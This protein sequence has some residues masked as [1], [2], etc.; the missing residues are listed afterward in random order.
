MK[1]GRAFWH[2]VGTAVITRKGRRQGS[3]PLRRPSADE[4]P[5]GFEP[6]NPALQEREAHNGADLRASKGR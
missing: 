3:M 2:V 5:V 6:T 1:P 4:P